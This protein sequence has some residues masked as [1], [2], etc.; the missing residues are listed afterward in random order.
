[1]MVDLIRKQKKYP[2]EITSRELPSFRFDKK[3]PTYFPYVFG[4]VG[5][6]TDKRFSGGV[7][8]VGFVCRSSRFLILL[9]EN[10]FG[11]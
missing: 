2:S 3:N 1:M 6:N 9:I 5:I 10:L 4:S 8:L 7:N 11:S